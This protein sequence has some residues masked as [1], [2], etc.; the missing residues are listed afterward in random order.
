MEQGD[1]RGHISIESFGGILTGLKSCLEVCFNYC[2][3]KNY[4]VLYFKIIKI[5]FLK[6]MNYD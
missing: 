1:I 5:C 4:I 3:M 6:K 2:F